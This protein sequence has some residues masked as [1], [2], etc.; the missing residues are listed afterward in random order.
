MKHLGAIYSETQIL[1]ALEK[2][3]VRVSSEIGSHFI[4]FCEFHDNNYTASAEVDKESGM[5]YCFSCRE[6]SSLERL[7]MKASGMSYFRAMRLIG[8]QEY[9]IASLIFKKT[10]VQEIEPFDQSVIDG[11]HNEVWGVGSEYFLTRQITPDSIRRFELGF[12]K[13][14]QM[15]TVPIHSQS[16]DIWGFVGRSVTGK[17]FKNSQGLK[18]SQTLFNIHRVWTSQ[19]VFVVESS[20]DAIRLDQVGIP[21]VATLGSGISK[22]QIEILNR[23]F[24]EIILVPDKDDAGRIMCDKILKTIPHA[25]IFFLPSGVKDCGDLSDEELTSVVGGGIFST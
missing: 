9:D 15:V 6:H 17:R 1:N 2:S 19:K 18:K 3:G 10:E 21:S 24:D 14:Q 20:F 11:L 23:S 7:V 25:Q 12:S 4:V 5:F 16:G 22:D 13:K 8:S